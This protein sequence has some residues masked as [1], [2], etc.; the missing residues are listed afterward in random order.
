[1]SAEFEPPPTFSLPVDIENAPKDFKISFNAHW[2]NWLY[3][4]VNWLN[5]GGGPVPDPSITVT[6]NQVFGTRSE[7]GLETKVRKLGSN[8]Q[9]ILGGQIFG[10]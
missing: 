4:L 8:G 9:I 10:G 2:I 5:L 6:V 1:M 7:A 3:K